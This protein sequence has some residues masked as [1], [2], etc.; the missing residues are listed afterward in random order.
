MTPPQDWYAN[1]RMPFLTLFLLL[2]PFIN[3]QTVTRDENGWCW[4][5]SSW[6]AWHCCLTK[7]KKKSH[8]GRRAAGIK[9]TAPVAHDA[10]KIFDVQWKACRETWDIDRECDDEHKSNTQH[11]TSI[12]TEPLVEFKLRSSPGRLII[13][14][15]EFKL[16][17]MKID[18]REQGKKKSGYVLKKRSPDL[19]QMKLQL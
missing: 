12:Q 16:V 10:R 11:G 3:Q 15:G 1:K 2:L 13:K 19:I 17:E 4:T 7:K 5:P 6:S 14:E 18:R 9:C 8:S